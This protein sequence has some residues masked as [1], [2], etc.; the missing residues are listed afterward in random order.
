MVRTGRCDSR[1]AT[2]CPPEMHPA[3]KST[4]V[5]AMHHGFTIMDCNCRRCDIYSYA[6]LVWEL[7]H[8]SVPYSDHPLD[9]V[10]VALPHTLSIS[11]PPF[12]SSSL[13]SIP[14]SLPRRPSPADPPSRS[15]RPAP[16]CPSAAVV[17]ASL[18]PPLPSAPGAPCLGVQA[19]PDPPGGP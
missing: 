15:V 8:T 19:C 13:P 6:V 17:P 1:A 12:V 11:L 7:Y 16:L 14:P 18:L 10:S 5:T 9:Q 4:M 2:A 3:H